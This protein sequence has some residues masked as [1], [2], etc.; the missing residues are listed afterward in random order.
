MGCY[1]TGADCRCCSFITLFVNSDGMR[2]LL[3]KRRMLTAPQQCSLHTY[4]RRDR[5]YVA[6]PLTPPEKKREE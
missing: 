6:P 2:H 5:S 1:D 3:C 4:E